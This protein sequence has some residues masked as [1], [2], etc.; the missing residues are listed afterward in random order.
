MAVSLECN[1][2]TYDNYEQK[3]RDKSLCNNVQTMEE[4][5]IKAASKAEVQTATNDRNHQSCSR[6]L[7]SGAL[8]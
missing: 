7:K 4:K 2:R 1:A 8:S 3:V 5:D 6:S